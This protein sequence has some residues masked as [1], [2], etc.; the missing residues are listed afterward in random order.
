MNK[1]H[2][3]QY[4]RG[5]ASIFVVFYHAKWYLNEIYSQRDLG[6]LLFNYGAFGVDL[7]FIIS[8]FI[9]CLSTEKLEKHATFN[10]FIRRFFRI[11]PLL[12][13]CVT[14]YFLTIRSGSSYSLYLKSLI[15]MH[16]DYSAG[17][18]FYGFNLL[19]TAWTITYEIAFY[20]V[21]GLAIYFNKKYRVYTSLIFI[22][23]I[24][25]SASYYFNGY[26][27]TDA[28]IKQGNVKQNNALALF[29][30]PMFLDFTYG[31]IIYVIYKNIYFKSVLFN[32]LTP[33]IVLLLF[34]LI[35]SQISLF[36]GHGPLKWGLVSAL[37]ILALVMYEKNNG[38]KKYKSLEYL[39][40]ISYSLYIVHLIILECAYKYDN[41]VFKNTTG[42]SRLFIVLSIILI[43]SVI[44]H[45]LIEKPFISLGRRFIK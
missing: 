31:I 43:I 13:I 22:I 17:S 18:P 34:S 38:I 21:F 28:Y 36:Y 20:A 26:I 45:E 11:Y 12:M 39:G 37:I 4:M 30:S 7:F 27:S 29:Y 16:S 8:G 32:R 15:P 24:F 33:C 25:I 44:V 40:D 10:F 14:I 9:I 2:S 5:L 42:F 19:D 1:V 41:I 23:V 35:A 6:F 3:I